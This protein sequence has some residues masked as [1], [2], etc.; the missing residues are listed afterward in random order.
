MV[1]LFSVAARSLSRLALVLGMILLSLVPV[2]SISTLMF[3]K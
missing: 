1:T 3:V 2:M